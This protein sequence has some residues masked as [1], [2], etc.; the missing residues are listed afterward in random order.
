MKTLFAFLALFLQGGPKESLSISSAFWVR[1][2]ELNLLV[3]YDAS[4]QLQTGKLT[5][6]K[7]IFTAAGKELFQSEI[8][9]QVR[10]SGIAFGAIKGA[11]LGKLPP[12]KIE[13]SV[14]S[15]KERLGPVS[16]QVLKEAAKTDYDKAA[17]EQLEKTQA[18]LYTSH[19]SMLLEFYPKKAPNTVR[20]FLKLAGKGFYDGTPFHRIVKDFM[21][22]GGDPTGTGSGDPGYTIKAEFSDLPHVK[23]TISMARSDDPDS[24]GCQFFLVHGE[25]AAHLD[26]QYTAFGKLAEG[27]DVL[28][29]IASVPV[30]M[31]DGGE[32]SKPL[33]SVVLKKVILVE[34][35]S[36]KAETKKP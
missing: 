24:A 18:V 34:R 21:I 5:L 2:M 10:K 19:G 14:E 15:G 12:E 35:L 36:A 9:W 29:R 17:S 23:G 7:A 31:S 11:E 1:G 27:V 32:Q 3:H 25:H 26:R 6:G 22:Q 30:G 8:A 13:V 4:V 28:D 16:F 20:N 33:E